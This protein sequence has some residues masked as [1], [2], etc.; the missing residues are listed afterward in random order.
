MR[1][2]LQ[3]LSQLWISKRETL[4]QMASIKRNQD[5]LRSNDVKFPNLSLFFFGFPEPLIWKQ[6]H[7]MRITKRKEYVYLFIEEKTKQMFDVKDY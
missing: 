7:K 3:N 5:Y 6:Q 2:Q 4:R 1:A